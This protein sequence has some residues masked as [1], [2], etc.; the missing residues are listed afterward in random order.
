MTLRSTCSCEGLGARNAVRCRL[1]RLPAT[2][3]E[4]PEVDRHREHPIAAAAGL[5]PLTPIVPRPASVDP[6]V[7]GGG[8]RLKVLNAVVCPV[9]I[10]MVDLKTIRQRPVD[11]LPDENVVV[12]VAGEVSPRVSVHLPN[13]VAARSDRPRLRGRLS[14]PHSHTALTAKP[15]RPPGSAPTTVFT[16]ERHTLFCSSKTGECNAGYE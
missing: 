2:F 10:H 6:R 11:S 14:H 8:Q 7:L 12:D 5:A 15:A 13:A 16:Y 1:A 3:S 4:V 9:P